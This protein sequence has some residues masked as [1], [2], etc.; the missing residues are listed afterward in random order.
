MTAPDRFAPTPVEGTRPDRPH[1]AGANGHAVNGHGAHGH[2]ANG[3]APHDGAHAAAHEEH[4]RTGG[5]ALM[6]VRTADLEPY[7]GLRYLSKLFRL[8]ALVLVLLLV[9]EVITGLATQGSEA[10]PTLVAEGS[11]LIV[12]AGLL[13]GAGDLVLLLIDLGHDVRASRILLGRQVAHL[14]PSAPAVAPTTSAQPAP[15]GTDA[16]VP[17][18]PEATGHRAD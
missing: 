7:V 15:V 2:A 13:W 12:L 5:D 17:R 1:A 8:I 18:R 9:A 3:H 4:R 16:T 6:Q 10:L 11:R 14:Q